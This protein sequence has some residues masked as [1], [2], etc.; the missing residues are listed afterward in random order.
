MINKIYSISSIARLPIK[1]NS[2]FWNVLE[3]RM[4][5]NKTWGSI[6]LIFGSFEGRGRI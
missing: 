4:G 2:V 5:Y 1:C 3:L 6:L